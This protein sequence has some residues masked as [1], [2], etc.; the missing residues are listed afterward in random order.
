MTTH[1]ANRIA[2]IVGFL[3]SI[4]AAHAQILFQSNLDTGTGW[5]VLQEATPSSLATFGFD[6][7]ALGIP[8]SPNGGGSTIGL[9]LAANAN[10]TIQ[11][12]TAATTATFSGQFRVTVDFWGNTNGPLPAG[13]TG[14]TEYI[15]GGVGFSGT[16]PRK[17]ASML[18]SME[19]GAAT[20]WRL[21]KDA[22][23][24]TLA[25]GFYNGAITSLDVT[26]TTSANPSFFFTGPFPGQQAPAIQA[27][28]GIALNGCIAFGWHTL[29]ILAD[30]NA[31]TAEFTVDSTLIG[32]LNQSTG[33]LSIAGSGSLTLL[34]S[35]TSISSADLA[36]DKVFAVFDHYQVVAVPE[37]AGVCLLGFA[38]MPVL[39]RRR[40]S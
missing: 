17:G 37:P 33:A 2:A 15:G 30:A 40:R 20:D 25:S 23:S 11:A 4:T 19:G 24:Q 34:D 14:S 39:L 5:T 32:T 31:G 29:S 21:D 22:A 6:Y 1:T 36:A 7:S 35:F 16:A 18:T 27:T 8:A 28:T 9:R 10:G 3:I 38:G 26:S 12:I 13:G